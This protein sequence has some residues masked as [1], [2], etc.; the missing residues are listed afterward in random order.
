MQAVGTMDSMQSQ[1]NR[2]KSLCKKIGEEADDVITSQENL[3]VDL[4]KRRH[5]INI[6][7]NPGYRVSVI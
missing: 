1:A 2:P 3:H 5:A 4:H 7:N 6:T